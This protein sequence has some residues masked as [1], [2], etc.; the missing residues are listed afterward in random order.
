MSS[1]GSFDEAARI[2]LCRRLFEDAA[3]CHNDNTVMME[4]VRIIF[5][6]FAGKKDSTIERAIGTSL[7]FSTRP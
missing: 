7:C 4:G 5:R 2:V 3:K 1:I 6:N